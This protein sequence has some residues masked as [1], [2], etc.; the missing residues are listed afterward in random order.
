MKIPSQNFAPR[1]RRLLAFACLLLWPALALAQ[2][3]T[4]T[5]GWNLGNTLEPPSGEGTW[6]PAA[7]QNL[8]NAVADAGFNTVRLPVAWDSHAN[9]STY[10]IDPA[11][12]AR[13]KQVVDWCYAKNLRVVV[14]SH[15]DA[16]WFENNIG[17][18]PNPTINQKM[19][20]YWTQI[21]E[22]FKGYDDRLL[23][24]A[25]NEPAADTAAQV[26]T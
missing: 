7:T 26:A 11:W 18:T 21:A 20:A 15:W 17:N 4:P 3:P 22:A 13:V 10:Q 14:N 2:L 23:F 9:Q 25:A 1:H 8:V 6:G 19:N 24:A 12:M 5:Y 16:G